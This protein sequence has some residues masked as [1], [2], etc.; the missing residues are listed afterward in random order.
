MR[1]LGGLI[2]RS[3]RYHA[4]LNFAVALGVLAGTAVLT[5]ALL[6]GDSVRG[7]LRELTLDRL[8]RVEEILTPPRFFRPDLAAELQAKLPAGFDQAVPILIVQANLKNP[9]TGERAGQ[10]TLIGC[11]ERFWKS[12]AFS[13]ERGK[14]GPPQPG[15]IIVNAPLARELGWG[16]V[17]LDSENPD[18]IVRVPKNTGIAVESALGDRRA[19]FS[20]NQYSLTAVVAASGLGRFGLQPTQQWPKNAYLHLSDLQTLV[21]SEADRK[22]RRLWINGVLLTSPTPTETAGSPS[23]VPKGLLEPKLEDFGLELKANATLGYLQLTSREMLLDPQVEAA[24]LAAFHEPQPLLTYLANTLKKDDREIPYSIVAA[25]DF[26]EQAPLGPFLDARGQPLQPLGF[27]EVVLN[28][29]AA[30]DLQAK[31]GDT[32]TL[33]YYDP[34]TTHGDV[35]EKTTTLIVKGIVPL[36][37]A[38]AD[39]LLTPEVPGFTDEKTLRR[40]DWEPPFPMDRSRIRDSD[41]DY[42]Q[43]Y[44]ATPKAFVSQ[45]TGQKLWGSRFGRMTAIRVAPQPGQQDADEAARTLLAK[46]NPAALGWEFQ[47]LRSQQLAASGGTVDFEL[48]F[49]GF[50]FFL[51]AAAVMLVALLFGLGLDGRAREIGVLLALGWRTGQVR[52][53][54]GGEGFLVAALGGLLGTGLGVAYAAAMIAALRDPNLWLAAVSTPFLELHLTTKSLLVGFT[55]GVLICGGTLL[56]T[57]WRMGRTPLQQLIAGQ[58]QVARIQ[59]RRLRWPWILSGVCLLGAVALLPLGA[60]LSGMAQAGAFFGSGS[61]CLIAVLSSLWARLKS[62]DLGGLSA[63]GGLSRLAARNA[64]RN[65]SRS[66]LTIGLVSA[67]TFL[68][69]AV[70]AF[71]LDPNEALRKESGNGG[72]AL[73]GQS[74][75]P[76]LKDLNNVPE[77]LKSGD[78]GLI[79]SDAAL[80]QTAKIYSFRVRPGDDASCSNL[81]KA[82][83]PRVLGL[84]ESFV[85]RGGFA[86]AGTAAESAEERANP[87]LLLDKPLAA[88]DSGKR[89][90][91]PVILDNATA[92]YGL[93]IGLGDLFPLPDDQGGTLTLQV[94]GLLDNS[95]LQGDLLVSESAFRKNFPTYP[96]YRFFLLE[97]PQDKVED[98]AR[99]WETALDEYGFDA[100]SAQERLANFLAVQNTYLKTFQS[101]GGLGLLLGTF[102]LA[103]VQVRNVLERRGELALLR[104]T[105]FRRSRLALLV[106]GENVVLLALGLGIGSATALVAIAPHLL[107]G[108][109]QVPWA[110]LAGTLGLVAL[111]GLL[112][113]LASVRSVL[114]APLLP[115]LKS[116]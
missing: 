111:A 11:D 86:W 21:R 27:G 43:K 26:R 48:L 4:A 25:M 82:R 32:L 45:E 66:V 58:S 35:V 5:G 36:A 44:R 96:G 103:M 15:E 62:G 2:W 90:P 72:F 65:P 50:S 59:A 81:F 77:L 110:T 23:R 67:A 52:Q 88:T 93:K 1:T 51:I 83:R 113:S 6:V 101:L 97:V 7:S 56:V 78:F 8:G 40:P 57:V 63:G 9:E 79:D 92:T 61:C 85:Q 29:H 13:V 74:D 68:L 24:A 53:V 76:V 71:Y 47:P 115:V 16:S 95:I 3:F 108:N 14:S 38:V 70:S 37:G 106:L 64:A 18:V 114:T 89:A 105:G 73:V 34:E 107:S 10:V 60:G 33:A 28:S 39:K 98:V 31:P 46:M 87:W 94:V 99:K 17:K 69:V 20:S 112:A 41:E 75:Q 80:L 109:A 104:A 42:W 22:Q 19:L 84:S 30:E 54:L 49:L 12:G 102:G 55:S 100:Q 91:I 116:E